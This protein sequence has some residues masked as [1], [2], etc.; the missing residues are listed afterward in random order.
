MVT[1]D[2]REVNT[3]GQIKSTK[4]LSP[5]EMHEK[6]NRGEC[7]NCDQKWTRT[8]RG[9]GRYLLMVG[10]SEEDEVSN[11]PDEES[12]IIIQ[13]DISCLNTLAGIEQLRSLRIWGKVREKQVHV[14]I[15]NGSTHNFVRTEVAERLN[16]PLEEISQFRVYVGNGESLICKHRCQQLE[17]ELQGT[18]FLVNLYILPIQ[19]PELAS[20][21]HTMAPRVG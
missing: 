15:D 2:V 1:A 8:H 17:L 20:P 5:A 21:R 16:L 9:N 12:D 19:G 4:R 6:R 14:L 18:K 13:G 11:E 10:M 3:G 7:Y